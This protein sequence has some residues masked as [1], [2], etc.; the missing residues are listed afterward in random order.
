[1]RSQDNIK[2]CLL[3]TYGPVPTPQYQTVEGGGMRVWGLA[4]GLK[5]NGVRVTIAV[6]NSFPQEL[7]E[8]DKINLVNWGLDE[9]FHKLINS[10]DTVVISYCMG[11]ASEFV[12]TKIDKSVQLVLDCYVPIYVEVSARDSD[13]KDS[14]YRG[15][16]QE[17][18]RYNRVLMRGDFFL[19]ANEVQ[20]IYYTGVL[21]S[22][23]LINPRSYREDRLLV[24]PFGILNEPAKAKSNPYSSLGVG[25]D[26]FVVLW[27]GGLYPWF[28]VDEYLLAISKLKADK[29]VK[30]VFVGTKNPF[31]PN[32]DFSKQH[33]LAYSYAQ[34]NDLL[35][36]KMFFV[37]WVDFE[38]RVD[39]FKHADVVVSLNQPGEENKF[40]WRTRVI[41]FVWGEIPMI[42]NGGD[43]LSDELVVQGAALG[44]SAFSGEALAAAIQSL[45][46]DQGRLDGMRKSLAALKK[47]YLWERVTRP[48]AETVSSSLHPF[49]A[50]LKYSE[51][52]GVEVFQSGA[53]TSKGV[54]S[55]TLHKGKKAIGLGSRLYVQAKNKGLKQ[56]AKLGVNI[57]KNKLRIKGRSSKKFVF[58]SN[59]IN[60]T[61]APLVLLQVISEF[62]E[63]YGAERVHVVAS[64][65]APDS[66]RKLQE[67]GVRVD[68]SAEALNGRLI[69]LQLDLKKN[70]FVL[71][72]TLAVH[73]NYREYILKA[74]KTGKLEHANWFIHED[75]AQLDIIAPQL[76]N[77]KSTQTISSLIKQGKLSVSVPSEH[78][79]DEYNNLFKTSGV[80]KVALRLP[81]D[82]KYGVQRTPQD[83]SEINFLLSGS[84]SDGRKAQL[85][86][87]SAFYMFYEEY[88]LKNPKQYRPF[89]LHLVSIGDDYYSRQIKWMGKSLLT[90]NIAI[91]PNMPYE[92]ALKITAKCNAVICCSLNET[93]ALYVAEGMYM[94]HVVLRNNSGGMEEQLSDGENGY[95][96]DHQDI[97]QF[98][99]RIEMILNK[100]TNSSADL[101]GMGKASQAIIAPYVE[102]LYLPTFSEEGK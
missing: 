80:R 30:F 5:Q 49:A 23:R 85:V 33:E 38:N 78:T 102:N 91:Y 66:Y 57:A 16:M 41:D 89:K 69:G 31:N 34:D 44:L 36:Q 24:V 25:R 81:I 60:N 58:I 26:D 95:F 54:L 62:V 1:M 72:N 63:K 71:I 27:F 53:P 12:A 73:P 46:S 61:G 28:R 21:S 40:S 52:I 45:S 55:K 35:G 98:A 87:I 56:S 3:I 64:H 50:E 20:K 11:D 70:D 10:Y 43:P 32:P 7:K 51:D 83:Y 48:L 86:A 96:I 97:R 92:E 99:S 75:L 82:K 22:L 29:K 74:L 94:G 93:F 88:Y 15:Y 68:K 8:H 6:N 39:W 90:E 101:M 14:E 65:F 17:A 100:S 2:S 84:P 79:R 13:D 47:Q 76:R 18:A 9:R 77:D 67:M 42:T 37:D 59:P 19:C 4:K